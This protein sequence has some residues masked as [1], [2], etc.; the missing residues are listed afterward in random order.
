MEKI[1]KFALIAFVAILY[2]SSPAHAEKRL[3]V[4]AMSNGYPSGAH[5]NLN[6][7]GKG[8]TY[9]CETTEDGNSIFVAEYGT[10]SIDWINSCRFRTCP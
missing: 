7:H 4:M 1:F 5:F 6:I 9:T 10:S 2:L 3:D 8:D